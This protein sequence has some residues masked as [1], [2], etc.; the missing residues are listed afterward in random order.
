MS[1]WVGSCE[2]KEKKKQTKLLNNEFSL[3]TGGKLLVSKVPTSKILKARKKVSPEEHFLWLNLICSRPWLLRTKSALGLKVKVDQSCLTLLFATPCSV[4][5]Q[6]PLSMEFSSQNTGVGSCSLLQGIFP[7]Q[8]SSQPRDRTQV[9][10]IAGGFFSSWATKEAC[11]WFNTQ[12]VFY[13][14]L[15]DLTVPIL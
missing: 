14:P 4:A 9:S 7:T 2:R 15:Q 10:H 12:L 1:K 13:K 3:K 11:T 5:C 8:G 6:A